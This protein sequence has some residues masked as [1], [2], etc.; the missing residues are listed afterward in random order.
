M[1]QKKKDEDKVYYCSQCL[2][3][4][5]IRDSDIDYCKCCGCAVIKEDSIEEW[6]RLSKEKYPKQWILHSRNIY[7]KPKKNE[8]YNK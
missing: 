5:I 1:Q 7:T 8:Y 6:E 4:A 2:S 3:L